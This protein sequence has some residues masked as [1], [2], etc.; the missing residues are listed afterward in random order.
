MSFLDQNFSF[1]AVFALLP[2]LINGQFSMQSAEFYTTL[3][4]II[5]H[6][7]RL[8]VDPSSTLH[9]SVY[10]NSQLARSAPRESILSHPHRSIMTKRYGHLIFHKNASYSHQ[11]TR[12]DGTQFNSEYII[13]GTTYLLRYPY[14][15]NRKQR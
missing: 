9:A 1:I 14:N 8:V 2:T 3:T 7:E 6:Q 15:S 13:D 5:S 11:I 10:L 4:K 12:F